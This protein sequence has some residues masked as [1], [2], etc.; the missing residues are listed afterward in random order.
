MKIMWALEESVQGLLT[1]QIYSL[2][3][4][5]ERNPF[6][7]YGSSF[8]QIHR[9][10]HYLCRRAS[11]LGYTCDYHRW[12]R[13][14]GRK[15]VLGRDSSAHH[16]HPHSHTACHTSSVQGCTLRGHRWTLTVHRYYLQGKQTGH[17]DICFY[18]RLNEFLPCKGP[19]LLFQWKQHTKEEEYVG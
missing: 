8:H 19:V 4:A 2:G 7:T 18:S 9:H 12:R 1:A 15:W 5:T 10:N 16:C 13:M 6:Q 11:S 14:Q 3:W 17:E